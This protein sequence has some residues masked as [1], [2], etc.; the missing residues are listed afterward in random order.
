MRVDVPTD[1]WDKVSKEVFEEVLEEIDYRRLAYSN[2]IEYRA[3][4]PKGEIFGYQTN[5]GEYYL[6]PEILGS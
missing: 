4:R 5:A 1:S 3:N 2:A 6:A